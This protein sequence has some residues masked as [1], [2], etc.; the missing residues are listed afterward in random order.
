MTATARADGTR[1]AMPES[2]E[3][4]F[5]VPGSEALWD[6]LGSAYEQQIEPYLGDETSR[7]PWIIEEVCP[8]AA[9]LRSAGDLVDWL[10]EEAS[11]NAG[12]D[13]YYDH[14][15][16]LNRDAEIVAAAQALIAALASRITYRVADKRLAEHTIT[17]DADGEPLADGERLYRPRPR[18]EDAEP[19]AADFAEHYMPLRPEKT[20]RCAGWEDDESPEPTCWPGGCER[21]DREGSCPGGTRQSAESPHA[22]GDEAVRDA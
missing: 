20:D 9:H 22:S 11:G 6:D 2:P 12:V 10:V 21:L 18:G 7:P 13:G 5:G 4:L 16:H 14:T 1:P 17:W 15:E 3:R 19:S 8:P